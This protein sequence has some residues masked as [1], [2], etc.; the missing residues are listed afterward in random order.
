VIG[1]TGIAICGGCTRAC[2]TSGIASLAHRVAVSVLATG[3]SGHAILTISECSRDAASGTLGSGGTSA[4]CTTGVAWCASATVVK[5]AH[6]AAA[7]TL[8]M[9]RVLIQ[10]VGCTCIAISVSSAGTSIT[11]SVTTGTSSCVVVFVSLATG[12]TAA[13]EGDT[14]PHASSRAAGTVGSGS[15]VTCLARSVASYLRDKIVKQKKSY[16]RGAWF[17]IVDVVS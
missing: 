3:T 14:V 17:S 13:G 8:G 9:S 15:A 2:T 5:L 16:K 1:G 10:V 7:D 4:C 12:H 11:C 6:L